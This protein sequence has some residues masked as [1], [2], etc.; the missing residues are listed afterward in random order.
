[1]AES[2]SETLAGWLTGLDEGAFPH[3]VQALVF[4]QNWRRH[5]VELGSRTPSE[6]GDTKDQDKT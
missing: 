2:V 3:K 5:H 4:K 1:M 6:E